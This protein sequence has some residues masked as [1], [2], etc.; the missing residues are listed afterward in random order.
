M[1]GVRVGFNCHD[2]CGFGLW[3]E[4]EDERVYVNWIWASMFSK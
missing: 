3:L 1:F 2:C 4:V